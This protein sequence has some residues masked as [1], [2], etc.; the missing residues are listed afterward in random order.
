MQI[1][2]K[3]SN[4]AKENNGERKENDSNRAKFWENFKQKKKGNS[5]HEQSEG[6]EKNER[7]ESRKVKDKL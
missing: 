5:Q 4:I 2:L 7:S 6:R 3:N 1:L